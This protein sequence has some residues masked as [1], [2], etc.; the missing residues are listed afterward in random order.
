MVRPFRLPGPFSFVVAAVCVSASAGWLSLPASAID[1]PAD[2]VV[3]E[4]SQGVQRF[5]IQRPGG[6][7]GSNEPELA[8]FGVVWQLEHPSLA[9][10][11]TGVRGE[12]SPRLQDHAPLHRDVFRARR[13]LETLSRQVASLARKLEVEAEARAMQA[14]MPM[15]VPEEPSLRRP[16][17]LAA[18]NADFFAMRGDAA[19][20][21]VGLFIEDRE[22]AFS[23]L[24]GR[25]FVSF[26]PGAMLNVHRQQSLACSVRP[27]SPVIMDNQTPA[28]VD[29]PRPSPGGLLSVAAINAPLDSLREQVVIFTG[30]WGT[31]TGT[32]TRQPAA[33][34]KADEAPVNQPR[35]IEIA[36]EGVGMAAIGAAF[37][38]GAERQAF[39]RWVVVTP[40]SDAGDMAIPGDGWVLSLPNGAASSPPTS[41]AQPLAASLTWASQLRLGDEVELDVRVEPEGM[42]H[43]IGGGPVLMLD[44]EVVFSGKANEPRH[45]RTA[46]GR[47][48]THG[49]LLVVDGRRPGHSLGMTLPELAQLFREFGCVEALNLDGGGSATMWFADGEKGS[50]ANRPSD[51]RE[52]KIPNGIALIGE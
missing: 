26:G 21:P 11:P 47:S 18:F 19:G 41:T 46:I 1:L 27:A 44:G 8:I 15:G 23:G 13:G 7:G 6:G 34:T 49:V 20:S 52:R 35:R 3:A 29:Q 17:V 42:H 14:T 5:S 28:G 37:G 25:A 30:R 43:A 31:S 12:L 38:T 39:S 16:R 33:T 50:I 51:G 24:Q 9:L 36:F 2:A 40:P 10:A 22:L 4:L 32:P 48:A 45:P